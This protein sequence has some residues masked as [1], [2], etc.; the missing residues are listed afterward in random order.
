MSKL[1]FRTVALFTAALLSSS[2]HAEVPVLSLKQAINFAL[3]YNYS[4]QYSAAQIDAANASVSVASGEFEPN[5]FASY[6]RSTSD[7][8]T[9]SDATE[10]FSSEQDERRYGVAGQ[11]P[12]GTRYSVGTTGGTA[13]SFQEGNALSNTANASL[14]VELSQPLLR[15]AGKNAAYGDVR[16]SKQALQISLLGL[17]QLRRQLI[18]DIKQAYANV[19]AAQEALSIAQENRD[20]AEKTLRYEEQ[21]FEVGSIAAVDIFRPDSTVALRQDAVLRAQQAKRQAVNQLKAFIFSQAHDVW[22]QPLR[23]EAL[24]QFVSPAIDL[25]ADTAIAL[26]NREE[27]KVLALEAK[28]AQVDVDR[29]KRNA[30]PQLD[31]VGRYTETGFDD[32]GRLSAARAALGDDPG[33]GRSIQ[34]NFSVPITNRSARAAVRYSKYQLK[35][36]EI[37][38]S[39]MR[40]RIQLEVDSAAYAV[41]NSWQRVKAAE[42]SVELAEKTLQAEEEKLAAGK[43]S[44]FYVLDL[45]SRLAAAKNQ[46][47]NALTGYY[48]AQSAY[49]NTL[50]VLQ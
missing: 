27:L 45:Q 35:Q 31:L 13:Q 18:T 46:R 47:V 2:P 48:I 39:S 9:N 42:R 29:N 40:Y 14:F 24:S 15:G 32:D 22:K 7:V 41:Q 44:S 20:L 37:D 1:A 50:G 33:L 8:V 43:S 4:L 36:V 3:E 11:L 23:V 12:W 5:L 17:Q 6:S 25:E 28:S 16:Q 30:L 49:Q 19:Y 26:A 38:Q 10:L 21:R 34:L